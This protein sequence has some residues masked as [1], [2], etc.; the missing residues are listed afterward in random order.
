MALTTEQG[1]WNITPSEGLEYRVYDPVNTSFAP[2]FFTD[3]AKAQ[4]YIR[5]QQ[6]SYTSPVAPTIP[7][8]NPMTQIPQVA[9]PMGLTM[10]PATVP[11]TPSTQ[12]NMG[13]TGDVSSMPL[14][15]DLFARIKPTQSEIAQLTQQGY[16]GSDG[17]YGDTLDPI[18]TEVPDNQSGGV[19]YKVLDPLGRIG[20]KDGYGRPIPKYFSNVNDARSYAFEQQMT[21]QATGV[22][23]LGSGSSFI[24]PGY[25]PT[26]FEGGV[27]QVRRAEAE[28]R[29]GIPALPPVPEMY[30]APEMPSEVGKQVLSGEGLAVGETQVADPAQARTDTGA[31][32]PLPTT[33]RPAL[34][35]Y[36]AQNISVEDK[37]QAATKFGGPSDIIEAH[38][39]TLDNKLAVAATADMDQRATVQFQLG[40]LY[41]SIKEGEPLPTWAATPARIADQMA[42]KRGIGT[43]S[44]A[45]HA[46]TLALLEA[47][48]DI[49]KADAE[50]YR[51]L[52]ELNLSNQQQTA[53]TNATNLAGLEKANL[54][55]RLTASVNNAENFLKLDI[56]NLTN[57]QRAAEA[58]YQVYTQRLLTDAA[59]TNAALQ[60]NAKSKNDVDTY[61]ANL[62]SS[63]T[64]YNANRIAAI[65]EANANARNTMTQF[66]ENNRLARES[67]NINMAANIKAANTKWYQ[68]IATIQNSNQMLA[69]SYAAQSELALR[70]AE[71]NYLWQKRRD[72]AHMLYE[73]TE[74]DLDR[75]AQAAAL[76]QQTAI[77]ASATKASK[78]AS[79]MSTMG[80]VVAAFALKGCWV[81]REV[82]G[83]KSVE[84]HKFRWWMHRQGPKWFLKLYEKKGKSFSKFISN[85]PFLKKVIKVWMDSRIAKVEKTWKLN[86]LQTV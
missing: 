56:Q 50:S 7:S 85:K 8:Y 70:N 33:T 25:D 3:P 53:I 29:L 35:T 4:E 60:F 79:I 43:S 17:M 19:Q 2:K 45:I 30:I 28:G 24:I 22:G 18:I 69:N 44:M 63:I 72:D 21:S 55:A 49:A 40:Q 78:S 15:T 67:F 61:F 68:S 73:S 48:I 82:Y 20:D 14:G 57:Q 1:N 39:G 36:Q 27:E 26:Q 62:D 75:A 37:L 6:E 31:I 66:Y 42:L 10:G 38:Q 47:G 11:Y 74:K 52:Q 54:D 16:F 86:R 58:S 59:A 13:M 77:A 12:Q 84:V 80:S 9:A 76:A 5:S 46:R 64:N 83:S 32:A 51:R 23:G 65:E 71:Y 34:G 81:A 41:D